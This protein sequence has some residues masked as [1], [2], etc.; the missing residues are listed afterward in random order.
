MKFP[1]GIAL[2]SLVGCCLSIQI[3]ILWMVSGWRVG[4]L[5]SSVNPVREFLRIE[6]DHKK[7]VAHFS[8]SNADAENEFEP[9]ICHSVYR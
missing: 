5:V 7:F 2:L 3:V 6:R 1:S 9:C 8:Y 4:D